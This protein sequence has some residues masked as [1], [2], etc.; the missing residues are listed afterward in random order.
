MRKKWFSRKFLL[1]T[2]LFLEAGIFK[3]QGKI[4][5]TIWL[6]ASAVG[7]FGF[8]VIDAWLMSNGTYK[9]PDGK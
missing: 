8:A 5:D 1:L 6:V 9:K 3:Y 4:G 7:V 2:F